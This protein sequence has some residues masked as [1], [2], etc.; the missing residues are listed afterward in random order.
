MKLNEFKLPGDGDPAF[1][2]AE[3]SANHNNDFELAVKTIEAMALSGANAVKIQTYT[4]DSLTLNINNE[5]FRPKADGLWSG[6]HPYEI[7]TAGSL[8]YEWQPR[9]KKVAE[10]LGLIFFSSPFDLHAVDFLEGLDVPLY[11]VASPEITDTALLAK[12]ASTGKPIIVSTGL[13]DLEDIELALETIRAEGNNKYALLKCT[14]Q[15]PAEFAYADLLTIP[16]MKAR[17]CCPVGVSD[18]SAGF[19][20]PTVA[21]S[22]GASIV[23]KHFILDR[24]LGGIDSAFS[25]EPKEFAFMVKTVRDAESSLG[26]ISYDLTE[27]DKL[28][29]RSLF[30]VSDIKEGEQF[31]QENVRSVRPGHGIHPKF[32]NKVYGR[33]ALV[34]IPRGT[35]LDSS[36]IDLD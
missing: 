25:M 33:K 1:I 17:F 10:A 23:E 8:P 4:A 5:Y 30:V 22:L 18:H 31:N 28:R 36:L 3:L 11:K 14:S 9:L 32:F 35:P 24:S 29:R 12:M 15:Y 21:T 20:V 19:L 2:I 6:K 16:D 26:G 13:A 7:F 27:S 34:D